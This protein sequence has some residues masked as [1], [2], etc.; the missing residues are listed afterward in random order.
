[1]NV[2]IQALVVQMLCVSIQLETTPVYVQKASMEILTM[3]YDTNV[4][5]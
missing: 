1:M 3:E 5:L 4:V 2:H